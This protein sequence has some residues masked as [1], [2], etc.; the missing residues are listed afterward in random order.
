MV[1][2]YGKSN[3]PKLGFRNTSEIAVTRWRNEH[4]IFDVFT[5]ILVSYVLKLTQNED[6]QSCYR[7]IQ[8]LIL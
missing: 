6:K 7:Q 3:R 4:E 2:F 8:L 5:D 1:M